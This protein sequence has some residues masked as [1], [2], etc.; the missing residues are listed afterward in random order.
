[1][2]FHVEMIRALPLLNM[3]IF[4]YLSI[5]SEATIFIQ[6]YSNIIR[7]KWQGLCKFFFLGDVCL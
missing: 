4:T 6:K 1:M 7:S 2:I 3:Y 5:E